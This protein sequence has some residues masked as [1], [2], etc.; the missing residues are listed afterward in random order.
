M[1]KKCIGLLFLL[2]K[3]SVEAGIFIKAKN[4]QL[5]QDTVWLYPNATQTQFDTNMQEI[6]TKSIIALDHV[7]LALSNGTS[8]IL[9]TKED[10]CI[11]SETAIQLPVIALVQNENGNCSTMDR[12]LNA[13]L[14]GA[15]G[16]IIYDNST[17]DISQN[18]GVIS[19]GSSIKIPAYYVN[20]NTGTELYEELIKIPSFS[21]N[22]TRVPAIQITLMPPLNVNPTAWELTLLTMIVLLGTSLLFSVLMHIY[23]KRKGR[24]LQAIVERRHLRSNNTS[25]PMGKELVSSIRLE[26][27]PTRIIQHVSQHLDSNMSSEKRSQVAPAPSSDWK[28]LL[29]KRGSFAIQMDSKS[30]IE[31]CV[32]C[33]EAFKVGNQV[34]KLPCRHEY[35]CICI[36][37]WLTSKSSECPLCKFDCSLETQSKLNSTILSRLYKWLPFKNPET[38]QIVVPPLIISTPEEVTIQRRILPRAP[39]VVPPELVTPLACNLGTSAIL[40]PAMDQEEAGEENVID[41]HSQPSSDQ[42][43]PDASETMTISRQSSSLN[44]QEVLAD[45]QETL[46]EEQASQEEN[47]QLYG[48]NPQFSESESDQHCTLHT[49]EPPSSNQES[50]TDEADLNAH[51]SHCEQYKLYEQYHQYEEYQLYEHYQ[52]YERQLESKNQKQPDRGQ[53]GCRTVETRKR[54]QEQ[55]LDELLQELLI[56]DH[57]QTELQHR[58][59]VQDQTHTTCD[60]SDAQANSVDVPEQYGISLYRFN[61]SA[62]NAINDA[63]ETATDAI[64]TIDEATDCEHHDMSMLDT[65]ETT[66]YSIDETVDDTP[67]G[68][69]AIIS[70][71][72]LEEEDVDCNNASDLVETYM[73]ASNSDLYTFDAQ[74]DVLNA[75]LEEMHVSIDIPRDYTPSLD[76]ANIQSIETDAIVTQSTTDGTEEASSVRSSFDVDECT[77]HAID[78]AF[79]PSEIDE[80]EEGNETENFPLELETHCTAESDTVSLLSDTNEFTDIVSETSSQI[81]EEAYDTEFDTTDLNDSPTND[82]NDNT[83]EA[84]ESHINLEILTDSMQNNSAAAGE[85]SSTEQECTP[86]LYAGQLLN[87]DVS[88]MSS[89]TIDLG[90]I[91]KDF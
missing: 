74:E 40:P 51:Y 14:E 56:Q 83:E 84:A 85:M 82:I 62:L 19:K 71:L 16:V 37:P 33:L 44:M 9:Y 34:R 72:A 57:E 20:H 11:A 65:N 1:K 21:L 39:V 24:R 69:D 75:E 10:P 3:S 66:V 45:E 42:T 30:D 59:C 61:N 46:L 35:H 22:Q 25:S 80:E 43:C 49:Q 79:Q 81:Y 50:H 73:D 55:L 63:I 41:A 52:Y 54:V 77:I 29:S 13:Q 48:T 12:I 7:P 31:T 6:Y 86:A 17:V 76:E 60:I 5:V 78:T 53:D 4:A 36:D 15:L 28:Q 90:D 18:K 26:S 89:Q 64:I 23:M 2:F 91:I 38:E 70:T 58:R 8:G 32:I 68:T 88:S 87:I 27:F 47:N 67:S